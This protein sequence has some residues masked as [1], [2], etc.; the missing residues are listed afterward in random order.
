MI[1]AGLGVAGSRGV[2][3]CPY[4]IFKCFQYL[5]TIML[6]VWLPSL[7]TSYID[8]VSFVLSS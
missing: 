5:R 3:E 1:Q 6:N 8:I 4:D 7:P 2:L